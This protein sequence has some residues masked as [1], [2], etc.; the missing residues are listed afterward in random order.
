MLLFTIYFIRS[1]I[2]KIVPFC[3]EECQRNAIYR[4][5]QLLNS[6][7]NTKKEANVQISNSNLIGNNQSNSNLNKNTSVSKN[8]RDSNF[9]YPQI[10]T[11][12][13]NNTHTANMQLVN[14]Q[15]VNA[16][17]VN[18]LHDNVQP[19]NA[20]PVT[21]QPL[22]AQPVYVQSATTLP[23]NAQ[24]VTAQPLN[25]Q[26]V[27]VQSATTLP[28]NAQP[29]TAQPVTSQPLTSQPE[30][31][32]NKILPH[33]IKQPIKNI[34]VNN[35]PVIKQPIIAHPS[36][37]S[38]NITTSVPLLNNNSVKLINS[39]S[40]DSSNFPKK[41]KIK[42]LNSDKI[43][44]KQ[45]FNN[46]S[47]SSSS[48]LYLSKKKRN[49]KYIKKENNNI[50]TTAIPQSQLV[51]QPAT[52]VSAVELNPQV[53]P[54]T[55]VQK[56]PQ[57]PV[58]TL[59]QPSTTAATKKSSKVKIKNKSSNE[60]SSSSNESNKI[61]N[62]EN[63]QLIKPISI[64]NNS[65]SSTSSTS[66]SNELK[67]PIMT[68]NDSIKTDNYSTNFENTTSSSHFQGQ[69]RRKGKIKR[70]IIDKNNKF[71]N[72]K[73]EKKKT[74][75]R[76]MI[77]KDSKNNNI[78]N[79]DNHPITYQNEVKQP[80]NTFNSSN[81]SLMFIPNYS[82]LYYPPDYRQLSSFPDYSNTPIINNLV[83]ISNNDRYPS[84]LPFI[85]PQTQLSSY[86]Q[87][88]IN[89]YLPTLYP[90]ISQN[91]NLYQDLYPNYK[92]KPKITKITKIT[93]R[94]ESTDDN[95]GP[96]NNY[97]SNNNYEGVKMIPHNPNM[98]DYHSKSEEETSSSSSSSD[99]KD[100]DKNSDE[101][102]KNKNSDEYKNDKATDKKHDLE[103]SDDELIS[104]IKNRIPYDNETPDINEYIYDGMYRSKP[105]SKRKTELPS[106]IPNNLKRILARDFLLDKLLLHREDKKPL[107]LGKNEPE[108]LSDSFSIPKNKNKN[109]KLKEIDVKELVK[110]LVDKNEKDKAEIRESIA[111][112]DDTKVVYLSD[113]L[114]N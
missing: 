113:I 81:N 91:P 108:I 75:R 56:H 74:K 102:K 76:K 30:I 16:L 82:N 110:N 89:S 4:Y 45:K 31:K 40:S 103:K 64:K 67:R 71:I 90:F 85:N 35:Q 19:V 12:K 84:Q 106:Y 13:V 112:H 72:L 17:H 92:N 107:K 54:V 27:Y 60:F 20:Q 41:E 96:D 39:T 23:V 47:S 51:M 2:I 79:N 111:T 29:V 18:G 95:Y 10:G 24:P 7:G 78:K 5:E 69:I 86:L 70:K 6:T 101:E 87:P 15:P 50:K 26:P 61:K 44:K 8:S 22:N 46:S 83:P 14:A 32:K 65:T 9:S 52:V 99:E 33:L 73:S 3:D 43:G 62:S 68:K 88:P 55:P 97:K 58:F 93:S 77:L 94:S 66:S 80:S 59:K 36:K 100:K 63:V 114:H 28:V 49:K 104:Y 11:N 37:Q 53:L 105:T 1:E 42:I 38:Q 109:S 25:A 98:D 48:N 34:L 57:T 21:S